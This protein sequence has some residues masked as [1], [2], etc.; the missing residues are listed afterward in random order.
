V[1]TMA[2][3]TPARPPALI[4]LAATARA[5]LR[6]VGRA[7]LAV[8][9]FCA[10]GAGNVWARQGAGNV[11]VAASPQAFLVGMG[12][13]ALA[14]TFCYLAVGRPASLP[15]AS[16][17]AVAIA[18][19]TC[20]VPA[21]LLPAP[22]IYAVGLM[23]AVVPL[24]RSRRLRWLFIAGGAAVTAV[25]MA[26][27]W[28]WGSANFDVFA[29]VQGST[30]ALLQGHNP[31]A[32]VYS[33]LLGWH[34][35]QQIFGS[36]SLCYGPMVVLLSIPSRLL[37][38][39]RLTALALNLSILAALVVWAR[40]GTGH[41]RLSSTITALWAASPFVPLMVLSE[42]TDSFCVA[43]VAWWLVL[44]ERHRA[45]ATVA[46]TLGIA[47]KPSML[48]LLVPLIFWTREA[49]RELIWS[50]AAT[51]VIVA[52]FALWTGVPQFVYDTVGIFGDLPTR[53]DGVTIDGLAAVL[54]GTFVPGGLLVCGIIAA[55]MVFTLRRPKDYGSLLAAGA[56]LLIVICLFGKQAF[57]NYYFIGAIGLLFVI[58]SGTLAPGDPIMSPLDRVSRRLRTRVHRRRGVRPP[59]TTCALTDLAPLPGSTAP[60]PLGRR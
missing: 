10:L 28:K 47:S 52:P 42:W 2:V 43:G 41:H 27:V 33:V 48:L 14:A 37:G 34:H 21:T 13:I 17:C 59:I 25:A 50:G 23:F 54:G 7:D 57:M 44:R 32:P 53:P 29:E 12:L 5:R 11:L 3:S 20:L 16:I 35:G 31:Y 38:D 39:V 6:G 24:V 9:G 1:R 58:G 4:V 30:A 51:L 22:Q 36:A 40:R 19:Q 45:W 46:L 18:A 49:R 60:A 55:G 8:L 15:S 26:A 56:G